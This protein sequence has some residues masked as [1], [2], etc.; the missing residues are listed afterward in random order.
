M[1]SLLPLVVLLSFT[2]FSHCLGIPQ[3]GVFDLE[4]DLAQGEVLRRFAVEREHDLERLL[5]IAKSYNLDVWHVTP[6]YVDI[7]FSSSPL[8]QALVHHRH[9]SHPLPTYSRLPSSSTAEKSSWNLTQLEGNV[10]HSDYHPLYEID[11]FMHEIAALYP[12]L[13]TLVRLGHSG[14][15]REMFG[16]KISTTG[17]GHIG[18]RGDTNGRHKKGKG[19]HET[20][21]NTKMGFVVTGAQHA[22]EWVATAASVYLTHA[23]VAN[24]SEPHS[25]AHLLDE[26]DFYVI[27]V[28]NPDGYEYTWE[29]DRFWYKNRMQ[30]AP[31]DGYKWKK[32]H[33]DQPCHHLYPGHR[34]FEAPEVNNIANYIITLPNL[35]A[36]VDFRSYG[37]MLSTPYSYSCKKTPVDAEDQIEAALGAAS[38]MKK[39]HGTVFTTG[40]LCSTLYRA[41]GNIVDWMY[42]RKGVKYSYAAH[43][44]DTGT[45]GFALPAEWIRPVGEET[46]NMIAYLAKFITKSV[47]WSSRPPIGIRLAEV[48]QTAQAAA[49]VLSTPSLAMGKLNIAHHKSYHPYR[50]DNIERVRRDE[51]EARQKEASEDGRMR[52]ADSEA[53]IDLLRLKAGLDRKGKGKK[54]EEDD[55]TAIENRVQDVEVSLETTSIVTAKGHINLFEDIE[56]Q[57]MSQALKLVKK[58]TTLEAEKGVP[59]APSA[60]DLKPWYSE[61]DKEPGKG[62]SEDRRKRDLA[63]QSKDDPL[64][65]INTQLSHSSSSNPTSS[66]SRQ[67]HFHRR[68]SHPAPLPP[69][70]SYSDSEQDTSHLTSR[71]TRESSERA[72]ALELIRRKKREMEG[73]ETPSTVHGGYGDVYNRVEVEEAH[74][75]WGKGG[76]W[77][78]GQDRERKGDFRDRRW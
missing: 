36:F 18:E 56:Q 27:P 48:P 61:R 9:T 71:L 74:R 21:P 44:R 49:T 68:H 38:A 66:T 8:P 77:G 11:G 30:L 7:Y 14:E 72:R 64:T 41:P 54:R 1:F 16:V 42:H 62:L 19:I 37:Q 13:V 33:P 12:D 6:E 53:R 35:K 20:A 60:K 31:A 39:S 52:L 17:T 28:P 24:S 69:P 25:M 32:P 10:Y 59:L 15:G 51:E 73:S 43:L 34:P 57:T 50:R 2:T 29:T 22:R 4:D 26:W 23:L 78:R 70:S 67:A 46:A 76:S 55:M 63:R 47:R 65:F 58:S 75:G 5:G 45:Y 3:Q 40:Q